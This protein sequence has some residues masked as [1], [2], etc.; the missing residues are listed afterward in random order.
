MQWLGF[1]SVFPA[2]VGNIATLGPVVDLL[3]AK[4]YKRACSWDNVEPPSLAEGGI[5]I[6]HVSHNIFLRFSMQV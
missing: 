4:G 3:V 1:S 6:Y 5:A 2:A